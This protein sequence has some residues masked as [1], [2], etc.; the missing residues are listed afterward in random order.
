MGAPGSSIPEHL[1]NP[2]HLLR[3]ELL[4]R[5]WPQPRHR[6]VLP[7]RLHIM[8]SCQV[9]P[10]TESSSSTSADPGVPDLSSSAHARARSFEPL[11][12]EHFSLRDR[13]LPKRTGQNPAPVFGARSQLHHPCR[14]LRSRPRWNKIAA[15]W[16]CDPIRPA[17]ALPVE[18]R[19]WFFCGLTSPSFVPITPGYGD[20]RRSRVRPVSSGG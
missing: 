10:G 13:L 15:A 8:L 1:E 12:S 3:H 9:P 11:R 19:L 2:T 17:G 6:F 4:P 18:R 7:L 14:W 16:P 20:A 5:S